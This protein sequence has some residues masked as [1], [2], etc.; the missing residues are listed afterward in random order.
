M[1][2]LTLLHV[3]YKRKIEFRHEVLVHVKKNI[4]DHDYALFDLGPDSIK[5]LQEFFVRSG[6]DVFC[7][8]LQKLHCCIAHAVVK[9]LSV[10]V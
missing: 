2:E 9:H 3:L 4:T 1:F 10:F 7:N 5:L 8:G 6:N